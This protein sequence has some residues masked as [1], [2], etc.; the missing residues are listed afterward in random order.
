MAESTARLASPI[1]R[2]DISHIETEY[3][4]IPE[5]TVDELR[6]DI[7]HIITEDDE[8]VDNIFSAKQQ[9]LLVQTLYTSWQPNRQFVA[10]ANVGVFQAVRESPIVPDV[11]L[12]M[13]VEIHD[14]WF[15]KYHRS[16][17]IW[18]FGKPP[19]VAIEIVSNKKG[20][21][22]QR[23]MRKYARFGFWYYVIY[24]PQLLLQDEP[25]QVYELMVGSYVPLDEPYLRQL[26]LGLTLWEGEFEDRQTQWL[27]WVD[28]DGNLLPTGNELAESERERAESER[29]RA[30]RL[31]QRLRELGVDPESIA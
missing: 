12:S 9:R 11:W 16:Y 26:E 17:F 2:P 19:E 4:D 25:L 13:D 24:D 10:D 8:P 15:K 1:E 31:A 6:P 22:S 30:N 7:S 28:A 21:E 5:F 27:R 23:K 20:G 14:D 18:E 29:A 3:D